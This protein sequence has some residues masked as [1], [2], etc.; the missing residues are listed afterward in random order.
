MLLATLA[1]AAGAN[2]GRISARVSCDR[3]V[4]WTASASTD[5]TA[6]ERANARVLVE[7]RSVSDGRAL[8]DWSATGP[9]GRFDRANDFEFSGSFRLPEDADAVDLRVTPL[10]RWGPDGSGDPP[11]DSRYGRAALSPKCADQPVVVE[12]AE[13]CATGGARVTGRNVGDV[14][15][16]A[17]V[18][19]D[20]VAL[21]DM[22]IEPGATD[23]ITVPALEGTTTT[24]SVRAGDFVVAESVIEPSCG[25][26]GP[27]AVVLERCSARQG[28]VL[29]TT[30]DRTGGPVEV[31]V[32]GTIVHRADA[33]AGQTLQR[34]LELPDTG[35]A[36]IEVSIDGTPHASGT[37]G[38]CEGP[39]AGVVTCGIP[40]RA[41]CGAT[42][43]GTAPPLPPP[44]PPPPAATIELDEPL[45]PRTGPW[46]RA[47]AL[48]IGGGL[49]LAGGAAIATTDRRRP[50]PSPISE[51]LAPYR[52]QWWDEHR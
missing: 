12:I 46:E 2:Y 39:V 31:R 22:R 45:L 6:E 13:E 49:L 48:F 5:G 15:V 20:G 30:G 36:P 28:V 51:A 24:I 4:N 42:G 44:P 21:R 38:G 26:S 7:Y 8:G 14:P 3:T 10:A 40:G 33:E 29:A 50:T 41:D 47:I 1:P 17:T 37:I 19:A 52:Q 11:G 25:N 16:T 34:T 43:A 9:E 35:E 23:E 18:A 27:A 32:G